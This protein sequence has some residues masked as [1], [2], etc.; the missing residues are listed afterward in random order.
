MALFC[1]QAMQI[2]L[3]ELVPNYTFQQMFYIVVLQPVPI[4][5]V[6]H[7]RC[8]CLLS[9][10]VSCS[11]ISLGL[12]VRTCSDLHTRFISSHTFWFDVNIYSYKADKSHV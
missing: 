6:S 3:I 12:V 9:P 8:V 10:S 7:L 2:N 1:L 11:S 5:P 4:Y